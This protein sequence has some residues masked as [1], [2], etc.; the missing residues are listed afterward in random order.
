MSHSPY[1]ERISTLAERAHADR[2]A[3]TLVRGEADDERAL[4]Y[5]REGVGPAAL[6]YIEAR[7]GDEQVRFSAVEFSLLERALNDWLD[8]YAHCYGVELNAEFTVREVAELLLKTDNIRDTAQLLT[9]VPT[10]RSTI[11][12]NY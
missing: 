12:K 9:G 4:T 6:V 5:L 2:E 7:T 1:W 10:R 8:C 3:S 11:T